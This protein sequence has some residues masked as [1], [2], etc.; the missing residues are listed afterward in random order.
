M[1]NRERVL[2]TLDLEEPDKVPY[3]E[4]EIENPNTAEKLGFAAP[5]S[6]SQSV[7]FKPENLMA[8][9][10]KIKG[11]PNFINILLPKLTPG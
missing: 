7:K 8:F 9:L 3:V 4:W 10:G 2:K 11:L 1:N 6:A 5:G